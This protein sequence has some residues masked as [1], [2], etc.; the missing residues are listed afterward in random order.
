MA[1]AG[2]PS[3]A[4][5]MTPLHARTYELNLRHLA[6]QK[7][8]KLRPWATERVGPLYHLWDSIA[9][10]SLATG[11]QTKTRAMNTPDNDP[12]LARRRSMPVAVN[13]ST[14]VD[15]SDVSLALT[16]PKSKILEAQAF[17]FGR[18]FDDLLISACYADSVAEDGTTTVLP[19]G[20]TI[21]GD[22]QAFDFAFIASVNKKF[23][24]NNIPLETDKVFVITPYAANK[25]L[26]MTQ[27]TSSDYVNAKAL[28]TTGFVE[29]WMGF[30]WVVSTLLPDEGTPNV[31]YYFAFTRDALGLHISED[32]LTR[33]AEDPTKSFSYRV[34]SEMSVGAL[35]IEDAHVV[36]AHILES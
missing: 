21:G 19:A 28:A 13:T 20:Q 35:R 7:Y 18:K 25:I 4:T 16:D 36:R 29:K 6:Q 10:L 27:A 17:L 26:A 14:L 15:R 11:M 22:T 24:D 30:T 23:M 8:S 31:K 1:R 3:V 32:I 33:V 9:A 5:N 34:Y 2:E 12:T